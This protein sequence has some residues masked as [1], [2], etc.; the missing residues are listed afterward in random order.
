MVDA[1]QNIW[2]TRLEIVR[3]EGFFY[4]DCQTKSKNPPPSFFFK[5]YSEVLCELFY[6]QLNVQHEVTERANKNIR[7]NLRLLN[8]EAF[9]RENGVL[10]FEVIELYDEIE[11]NQ[12]DICCWKVWERACWKYSVAF[13]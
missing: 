3:I 7:A 10:I 5:K 4:Y 8:N 2:A 11:Y 12:G 9:L 1:I 13:T 6:I